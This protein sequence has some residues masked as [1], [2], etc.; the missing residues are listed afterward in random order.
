MLRGRT[1]K[2][3]DEKRKI[4]HKVQ[5]SVESWLQKKP[6]KFGGKDGK[7][8]EKCVCGYC[9]KGKGISAVII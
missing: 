3:G 4:K 9:H 2:R 5:I 6:L 7:E 8:A 1:E